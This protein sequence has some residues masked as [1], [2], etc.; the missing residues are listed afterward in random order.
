[1]WA[2][3]ITNVILGIFQRIIVPIFEKFIKDWKASDA[4]KVKIEQNNQKIDEWK[5]AKALA[6]EEKRKRFENLP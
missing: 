6:K 2:T 3:I 4:V 5:A 1:M